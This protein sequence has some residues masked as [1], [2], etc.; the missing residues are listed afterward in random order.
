MKRLLKSV[1]AM[2]TLACCAWAQNISSAP[3]A[4]EQANS[5]EKRPNILFIIMDDVGIDQMKVFGYG[6]GTP[7]RTP[8]FDKIA[9][10]GVRF[11]N[12]WSMPECSPKPGHFLRRTV[13]AADQNLY[14]HTVG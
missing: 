2:V 14:R 1:C 4:N 13:P 3:I 5:S 7:P 6:G 10:A 12:A 11:R 9:L 8:N